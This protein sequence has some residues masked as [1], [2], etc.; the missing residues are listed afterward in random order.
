[1]MLISGTDVDND[2]NIP[3]MV[4]KY[5]IILVGA[6]GGRNCAAT[7]LTSLEHTIESTG[8]CNVIRVVT[9]KGQDNA[10]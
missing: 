9:L 1:M 4:L 3:L 6:T 2:Y 10:D 8:K 7:V 5:V